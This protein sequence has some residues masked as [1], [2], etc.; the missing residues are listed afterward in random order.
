MTVASLAAPNVLK[1][2]LMDELNGKKLMLTLE[3]SAC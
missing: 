3:K 1:I 2:R